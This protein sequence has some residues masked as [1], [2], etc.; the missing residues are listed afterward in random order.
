MI[1]GNIFMKSQGITHRYKP[2]KIFS[3]FSS[4]FFPGFSCIVLF[5]HILQISKLIFSFC[6]CTVSANQLIVT[7]FWTHLSSFH[8][9]INNGTNK[10]FVSCNT[11]RIESIATRKNHLRITRN[12]KVETR[13]NTNAYRTMRTFVKVQKITWQIFELFKTYH[14]LWKGSHHR[15][16]KLS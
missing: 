4:T 10:T 15:V 14:V 12:T 13:S 16:T 3:S 11:C 5:S 7:S 1:K 2:I 8:I 6:L 9:F